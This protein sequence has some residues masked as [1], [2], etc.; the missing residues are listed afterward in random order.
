MMLSLSCGGRHDTSWISN[1]QF[2]VDHM[3]ILTM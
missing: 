2:L 3:N 1:Q